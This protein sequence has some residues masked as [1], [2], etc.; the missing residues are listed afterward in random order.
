MIYVRRKK[1][2]HKNHI[3]PDVNSAALCGEKRDWEKMWQ[4]RYIREGKP[5]PY[6]LG[7]CKKCTEVHNFIMIL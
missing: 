4:S 1:N 7:Y 3:A 5:A 6:Y 2:N